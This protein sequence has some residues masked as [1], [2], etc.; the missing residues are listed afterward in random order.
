MT[1]YVAGTTPSNASATFE[2]PFEMLNLFLEHVALVGQFLTG[3]RSAETTD[4]VEAADGIMHET[5]KA[6]G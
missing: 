6:N 3:L 2:A 4:G 1:T 5:V